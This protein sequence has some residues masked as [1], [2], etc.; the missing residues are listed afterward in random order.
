MDKIT[1]A[2]L[3]SH[4]AVQLECAQL[5][6][7]NPAIE[8]VA[9]ATNPYRKEVWVAL[10]RSEIAVIEEG[11][12]LR[13]AGEVLVM[14]HAAKPALKLLMIMESLDEDRM[15]WAIRLGMRGV[16]LRRELRELLGKAIQQIHDG[17]VWMPRNL[18][19]TFR[20]AAKPPGDRHIHMDSAA[21]NGRL[22]IH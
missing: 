5:V 10:S 9:L 6:A 13:D 7:K 8:L 11:L 17:D 12:L 3:A 19:S 18:L 22:R 20:E 16:I 21:M 1:V 2:F 15:L 4:H 14:L